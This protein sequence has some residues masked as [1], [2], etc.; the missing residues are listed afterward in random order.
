MRLRTANNRRKRRTELATHSMKY[1]VDRR[2]I[3]GHGWV[4]GIT[5]MMDPDQYK[6]GYI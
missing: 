3:R 1:N 5:Y 2:W 4:N 6:R